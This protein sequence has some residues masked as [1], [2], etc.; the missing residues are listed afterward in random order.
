MTALTELISAG[1][2]G[3]EVNDTKYIHSSANII[4]TE[5]GE[6]WQKTGMRATSTQQPIRMPELI[7]GQLALLQILRFHWQGQA[8][9]GLRY[10]QAP[11]LLMAHGFGM[12]VWAQVLVIM[13]FLQEN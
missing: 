13:K 3:S 2:G 6:K 4:T 1:G 8:A 12:G 5:S 9:T 11:S 7:Q 10:G